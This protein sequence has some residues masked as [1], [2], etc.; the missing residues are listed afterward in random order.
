MRASVT[1]RL[2]QARAARTRRRDMI[3]HVLTDLVLLGADRGS[4]AGP[5]AARIAAERIGHYAH[6]RRDDVDDHAAPAR[7]RDANRSLHG[8]VEDDRHTVGEAN[9]QWQAAL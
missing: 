5:H 6:R 1:A 2:R 3:D 7:M 8:I 4:S 9:R